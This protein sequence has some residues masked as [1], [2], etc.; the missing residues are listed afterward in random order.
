MW[1]PFRS[2]IGCLNENCQDLY[3]FLFYLRAL[4]RSAHAVAFV[5]IPAYLYEEVNFNNYSN[6]IQGSQRSKILQN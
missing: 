4:I 2:S 1:L 3:M 6:I 5:T